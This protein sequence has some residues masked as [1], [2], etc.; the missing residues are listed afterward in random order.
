MARNVAHDDAAPD[1]LMRPTFWT[2]D[3]PDVESRT[4]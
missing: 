4:G 3:H 2:T 1:P